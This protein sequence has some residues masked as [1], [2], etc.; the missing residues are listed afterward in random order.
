MSAL[1]ASRTA[2]STETYAQGL[3]LDDLPPSVARVQEGS[4]ASFPLRLSHVDS[5]LGQPKDG[6]DLRTAL[7]GD[8]AHTI[9]PLAGQGLNMGLGDIQSLVQTLEKTV[10]N[11]GDVGEPQ[12]P[13]HLPLQR[14]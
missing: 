13:P 1:T 4:V 9:H 2:T 3:I 8:A 6:R 7:V 14:Y 12:L 11:G 10:E 5:Y